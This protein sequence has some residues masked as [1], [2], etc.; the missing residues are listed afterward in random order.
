MAEETGSAVMTLFPQTELKWCFESLELRFN[1]CSH[2]TLHTTPHSLKPTYLPQVK[3]SGFNR[4]NP[5]T[6][7]KNSSFVDF[8]SSFVLGYQT[9]FE[10]ANVWSDQHL[11]F[12]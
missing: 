4:K 11:A 6:F 10:A 8:S 1:F 7:G 2:R 3:N 12:H 9:N 5:Q